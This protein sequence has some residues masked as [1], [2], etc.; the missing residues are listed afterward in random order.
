MDL[1]HYF[2]RVPLGTKIYDPLRMAV[3]TVV[4]HIES[5]WLGTNNPW[6]GILAEPVVPTDDWW[7][8]REK[9]TMWGSQAGRQ[10]EF[11]HLL[12]GNVPPL[13]GVHC[14]NGGSGLLFV[15]VS[16]I[17][18]HCIG[19]SRV[20]ELPYPRK[21]ESLVYTHVPGDNFEDGYTTANLL[22]GTFVYSSENKRPTVYQKKLRDVAGYLA[23]ITEAE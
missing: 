22:N 23:Y 17:K 8:K 2:N 20:L 19:D 15:L 18:V 5:R 7:M 6:F 3:E 10:K 4:A 11:V 12:A 14:L 1:R 21:N 9:G 16:E 13:Y